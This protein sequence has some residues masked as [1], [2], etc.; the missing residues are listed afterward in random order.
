MT[1]VQLLTTMV[2]I[3][4]VPLQG[5]INSIRCQWDIAAWYEI[6]SSQVFVCDRYPEVRRYFT[7]H[8]LAHHM[9]FKLL[10]QK[11]RDSYKVEWEKSKALGITHFGREYGM[12][13]VE[14][15]FADDVMYIVNEPFKVNKYPPQ[16]KKRLLKVRQLMSL[17]QRKWNQNK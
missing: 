13:N 7:T 16:A 17:V 12:T 8:E 3:I 4:I 11:Q 9:W 6:P 5:D 10:T 15:G 1:I 14:E 2:S